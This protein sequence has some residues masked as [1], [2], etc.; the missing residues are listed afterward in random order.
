MNRSTAYY[1]GGDEDRSLRRYRKH[2][3]SIIPVEIVEDTQANTSKIVTYVGGDAYSAP[4]AHIKRTGTDAID[5]YHYLHRDYLGSIL[6]ITDADGDVREELQFGAWGTVDKFLDS[7]GSTTF[8]HGSLLGRGYTGHE[9]FFEVSLI[10]MNGRM[11]DAQLGRFLSPDNHVQDPFSTQN[12][13][14][15]GYVLTTR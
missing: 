3:S 14:R 12:Y 2:Y 13:N 5:G 11:Y 4:I 15:Y 1:G 9:H 10:H 8:G 6:A 7:T